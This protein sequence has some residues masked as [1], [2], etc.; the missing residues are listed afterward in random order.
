[1]SI[2]FTPKTLFSQKI[3]V[4]SLFI[5]ASIYQVFYIN[6]WLTLPKKDKQWGN[7][8]N[9]EH[10]ASHAERWSEEAWHAAD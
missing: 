5:T 7:Q 8:T 3:L 1:M 4:G 9:L 10:N 2:V 6:T